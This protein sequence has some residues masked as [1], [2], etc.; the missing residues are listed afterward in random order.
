MV[1]LLSADGPGCRV[2]FFSN[3]FGN[4]LDWDK[5]K[6][7]LTWAK[8][9]KQTGF[10]LIPCFYCDGDESAHIRNAPWEKHY[11]YLQ[12]MTALLNPYVD[13]YMLGIEST[14]YW[15]NEY[16]A[17]FDYWLRNVFAPGKQIIHHWQWDGKRP[18]ADAD[19]LAYEF[20]WYPGD[21]DQKSVGQV[22]AI[23]QQIINA[24]SGRAM[25]WM[26]YNLNPNGPR[27]REQSRMLI[28][29][30]YTCGVGGP[31]K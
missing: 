9:A 6:T 19:V 2:N 10:M 24:G 1:F 8:L 29:L 20:P 12:V 7:L 14:E 21:G 15:S 17:V 23:A 22:Q 18:L 3:G 11:R 30:P 5:I 31:V 13:C 25:W 26:E 4:D 16:H 27:I 28:K